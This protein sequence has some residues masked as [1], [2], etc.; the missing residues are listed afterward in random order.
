MHD[1]HRDSAAMRFAV[2]I[3]T[4]HPQISYGHAVSAAEYAGVGALP[5]RVFRD[6]LVR[7]GIEREDDEGPAAGA[8][9]AA[10]AAAAPLI[11]R[12]EQI[13]QQF[14]ETAAFR[15]ALLEIRSAVRSALQAEAARGSEP[16]PRQG[17]AGSSS[18]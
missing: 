9:A 8:G 15:T 2:E 14:A 7:V 1:D 10:D 13:R 17:G 5:R 12:L 11:G 3:L 4:R 18:R 16:G 6:A